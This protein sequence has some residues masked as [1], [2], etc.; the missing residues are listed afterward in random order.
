MNRAL[1]SCAAAAALLAAGCASNSSADGTRPSDV[2]GLG[3]H[4]ESSLGSLF[5]LEVQEE[6]RLIRCI[7]SGPIAGCYEDL[8]V[9]PLDSVKYNRWLPVESVPGLEIAIVSPKEVAFRV[10]A[11]AGA[12]K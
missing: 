9:V 12:P 3:E 5:V 2:L 6:Y 1:A 7:P 11:A 4:F 10:D 8:F